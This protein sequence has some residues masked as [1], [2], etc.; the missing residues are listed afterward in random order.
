MFSFPKQARLL[1]ARDYREVFA[2]AEARASHRHL[3]LLAR[4]NG[5]GH[6]RLGLVIAKKHVRRAVERNRIKRVAR[7]FFRRQAP[8]SPDWELNV[9][10][11]A[12]KPPG[13]AAKSRRGK[14]AAFGRAQAP[15]APGQEP[16]TLAQEPQ[17]PGM[18]VIVLARG[19]IADLDNAALAAILQ[20]QWTKLARQ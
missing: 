7:E 10:A 12:G 4:R 18:D 8:P 1:S 20:Q 17:A 16:Q 3:L 19:G 2:G 13:P 11:A 14:P 5:R 15:R 9:A 6:H